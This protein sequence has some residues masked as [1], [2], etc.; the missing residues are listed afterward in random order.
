[1]FAIVV[2]LTGFVGHATAIGDL[3]YDFNSYSGNFALVKGLSST[4]KGKSTLALTIPSTVTY[5]GTKYRVYAIDTNAFANTSAITSV[6]I[7]WGVNQIMSG[8]FQN[9]TNITSIHLR[10]SVNSIGSNAFAGCTKLKTITYSAFQKPGSYYS[11]SFPSNSGTLYVNE[12][13]TTSTADLKSIFNVSTVTTSNQQVYDLTIGD[14]GNQQ[15]YSI[16]IGSTD[17]NDASSARDAYVTDWYVYSGN[18]TGTL[19]GRATSSVS[20]EANTGLTYRWY[21]IG[22]NALRGSSS[23]KIINLDNCTNL[24]VFKD[25]A[26]TNC[27]NLT[28]FTIPASV[29]NIE[30]MTFTI[31]CTTLANYAVS[32]DNTTY[33]VSGGLLYNKAQTYLYRCPEGKSGAISSMPT[34]LLTVSQNAFYNCKKITRVMLPYGVTSIRNYAFYNTSALT[35]LRVPSTV[36][37]LYDY[38]FQNMTGLTTLMVNI[39]TPPT[40]TMSNL[41][42]GVTLSNVSLYVPYGKESAYS[43]A[44]WT[45]FKNVNQ[46]NL[47]AYDIGG[48]YDGYIECYSITQRAA[49]TVDGITFQGRARVVNSPLSLTSTSRRYVMGDLNIG[50]NNYVVNRIGEYAF[51]SSVDFTVSTAG[52]IDTI[53]HDAFYNQPLTDFDFSPKL[54]YIGEHAFRSTKLSG[55][56]ALPYG[57]KSIAGYAFYDGKYSR[58]IIPSSCTSFSKTFCKNTTTLTEM[59]INHPG[60][61][62]SNWSFDFGTVPTTCKI[63]VP[64]GYV[65]QFK[66][67]SSFSSRASYIEA[68]AYDFIGYWGSDNKTPHSIYNTSVHHFTITSTASTTYSGTTYAGTVKYVYNPHNKTRTGGFGFETYITDKTTN[69]SFGN[70]T[71]LVTELGDSCLAEAPNVTSINM[72]SSIKRIGH[73]AFY[74]SKAIA[75]SNLSLPSGLTYIGEYAFF[76]T[77]I[78]GEIKI[79]TSVTTINKNAFCS[80]KLTA[81][82][83]PDMNLPATNGRYIGGNGSGFTMWVPNSRGNNWY[84]LV[85]GWGSSYLDFVA[86]WIKPTAATQ[87]F[88]SMFPANLS[89]SNISAYYAS[90]YSKNDQAVTLTKANQAPAETALLLTDLTSGSE[91]R[92]KRP[93]GSVSAPMTNYFASAAAGSVNVYAQTVGYYWNGTASTPH[94]V[95]PT[96]A[97]NMAVGTAYLKLSSAEAGTFTDIYS[98][99]WPKPNTPTPGKKGDVDGNTVVDVQDLNILINIVLGKDS[100]SKYGGRANVDGQGGIDVQDINALTNILVGK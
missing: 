45:G 4:G 85:N 11:S 77:A 99:L 71:Y 38:A 26:F 40:K 8:A 44:G 72:P 90:N 61:C 79:P 25:R 31:G 35:M 17:S 86:V 51:K 58:I 12:N 47:Q 52:T 2:G 64:T 33:S 5:G 13:M 1:M 19:V 62:G 49:V 3:E 59:V 65:K 73:D 67:H 75:N 69:S 43:S 18:T 95:R 24:K 94:W 82:Y 20:S 88:S 29:N 23:V 6:T 16:T 22:K 57:L 66:N 78:S 91:Y 15:S 53:S 100:A 80:N 41:L 55:T 34:T 42:S 98:N 28:S 84:N 7:N 74:N 10:S 21:G 30:N 92:I 76:N 50:N 60:A 56:I 54:K 70:K 87:M 89:G 97:H 63:L 14:S 48:G 68:G 37:S 83:F 27:T 93:S 36:N 39:N 9:C 32:S 46:N 81:L 96:S